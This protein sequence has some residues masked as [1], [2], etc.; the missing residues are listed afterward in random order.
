MKNSKRLF[1]KKTETRR[2]FFI[3]Q[4]LLITIYIIIHT[5]PLF[6]MPPARSLEKRMISLI[7]NGSILF[8]DEQGERLLQHNAEQVFIP[9]SILKILT[10][11]AALSILGEEYRFKTEFYRNKKNSLGIKG[12][13]D[14]FLISE[15][16]EAIGKELK[17]Q[18]VATIQSI[19]LDSGMFLQEKIPGRSKTLNPYDALNGALVV[20]FNSLYVGRKKDGTVYSAEEVTPLTPLSRK[21]ALTLSHGKKDRINLTG[22]PKESLRYTGELFQEIFKQ[23][24]ITIKQEKIEQGAITKEWSLQ[25]THYNSKPLPDIL[26]G[27]LKYSNNYI[28]NQIFLTIGAKSGGYPA[29]LNRARKMIKQYIQK[30]YRPPKGTIVMNE[31][32]GLSRENRINA[33]QMIRILNRFRPYHSLLSNKRET[34]VKSGTLTGVY[35]YAGYIETEK[36]LRPFVIILNQKKNH[37]D[38][39]LNLL[40]Q[41]SKLSS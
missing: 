21:K 8:L 15:E 1:F 38:K 2:T 7:D 27:L 41:Y 23:V 16:I 40:K 20:N 37:R 26:R 3:Q 6:A 39:L 18:G 10:A 36:G 28:A 34:F 19:H 17:A 32:S 30:T 29:S 35:N 31:A 14:P 9:A 25:Y 5:D 24:G 11:D 13:G 33:T 4:A 12:W 22:D